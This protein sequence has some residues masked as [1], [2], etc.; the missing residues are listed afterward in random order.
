MIYMQDA[1]SVFRLNALNYKV[2]D[3]SV[4]CFKWCTTRKH[5]YMPQKRWRTR[6]YNFHK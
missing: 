5:A 6:E 2:D 4:E 1:W 3:N